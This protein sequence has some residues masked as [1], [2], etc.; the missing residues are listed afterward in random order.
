MEVTKVDLKVGKQSVQKTE[1]ASTFS[2]NPFGV[3][4]KGS[5]IQADVFQKAAPNVADK[6]SAKSKIFASAIVGNINNF[7]SSLKSRMNAV[8]SFGQKI[9]TNVFD[10][11]EKAKNTE[12]SLDFG[13]FKST[14]M[15]KMFPDSQYKVKNLVKTPVSDLREMWLAE[16]AI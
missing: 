5:V 16:A 7:N 8:V 1:A 14:I 10:A 9:K 12:I 11:I 6:I 15:N 3:S 2:S 13:A 4:F